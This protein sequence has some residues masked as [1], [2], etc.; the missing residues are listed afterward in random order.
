M[1]QIEL[2]YG[3]GFKTI[4]LPSKN[5]LGVI[6]PLELP[7]PPDPLGEIRRALESPINSQPLYK[8]AVGKG[9]IVILVS[10]IS[11]PS[12]SH[13]I[14][15]PIIEELHRA[16]IKDQQI[17]IVFALGNHRPHTQNEQKQLVGEEIYARF[18]CV[19]HDPNNCINMGKTSRGTPIEVFRPVAG[20]DLII[21]TGNLE[22]HQGAGFTGGAKV[23]F[24]GVCSQ[25]GIESNHQLMAQN[26]NLIG[27]T[28]GNPMRED[29]EEAAEIA[30]LDFIINIV[31]NTNNQIIKA[32]A[33]DFIKSHRE[34]TKWVEKIY[35][36]SFPELADLIIASCGGYPKDSNLYQAQ[37]GLKNASQ[38]LTPGGIII[39]LAE[40][41]E[42]IGDPLFHEWMLQAKTPDDPINHLQ[43]KFV[44][45][46]HK[47]AAV[48]KVL[49]K[50]ETFLVSELP[51]NLVEKCFFQPVSSLSKAIDKALAKLPPTAKILVLPYAN[52]TLPFYTPH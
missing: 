44:L 11:R 40:C 46:A 34:G 33:G 3:K 21:G 4:N 14:L 16:D 28:D 10:D 9:K 50:N 32:V 36:R 1:S 41:K 8:I 2:K 26:R 27:I 22:F 35:K 51:T 48:C 45:G 17:T 5:L 49:K 42:G 37:K 25:I 24:P 13:L 30:G 7:V 20:A 15:P 38:A 12:P 18:K 52:I 31:L 19:D 47:A 6:E 29:L 23:L 43:N 39:L